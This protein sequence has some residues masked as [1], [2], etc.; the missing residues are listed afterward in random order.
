M[1][2]EINNNNEFQSMEEELRRA[3]AERA[4]A[5]QR[6]TELET[7]IRIERATA[8]MKIAVAAFIVLVVT[9]A[10]LLT[11]IVPAERL[12]ALDN[13]L[14]VFIIALASVIGAYMGFS[15]WLTRR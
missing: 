2:E 7:E 8:Q 13:L 12:E 11:P 1:T 15:A 10:F 6:A 4:E 3:E 9:V 14:E 5:N